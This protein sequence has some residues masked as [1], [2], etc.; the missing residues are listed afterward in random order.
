[1][2][3]RYWWMKFWKSVKN[4]ICCCF[5]TRNKKFGGCILKVFIRSTFKT[6]DAVQRPCIFHWILVGILSILILSV[7]NRGVG[8]LRIYPNDAAYECKMIWLL[9]T[10]SRTKFLK[11]EKSYLSTDSLAVKWLFVG[12]C[13]SV[14]KDKFVT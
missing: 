9:S 2:F 4:D 5:T 3:F 11:R 14:K 13:E 7:E 6:W 1:M 12:G 8:F 10:V